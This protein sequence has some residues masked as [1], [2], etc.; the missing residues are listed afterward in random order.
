[1]RSPL[2]YPTSQ[3]QEI[4]KG[5]ITISFFFFLLLRLFASSF[6]VVSVFVDKRI[7]IQVGVALD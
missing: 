7:M 1:M 5:D 4:Q 2:L 3:D 6:E